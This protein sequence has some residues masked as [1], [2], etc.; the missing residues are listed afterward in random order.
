MSNIQLSSAVVDAQVAVFASACSGGYLRIYDGIQP[1]SAEE[2]VSSQVL[3]VE[4]RFPDNAFSILEGGRIVS[5]IMEPGVSVASITP[6]WARIFTSTGAVVGDITAGSE[7][8]ALIVSPF[9]ANKV[10]NCDGFSHQVLKNSTN[11]GS[12]P[13]LTLHVSPAYD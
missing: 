12:A 9:S 8:T 1:T 7:G 6:T 3:G 2:A 13:A 5:H 10:I 4:L 11:I